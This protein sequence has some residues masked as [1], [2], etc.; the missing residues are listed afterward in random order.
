MSYTYYANGQLVELE[1]DEDGFV[2]ALFDHSVS[3]LAA[4]K[5]WVAKTLD[6]MQT[7]PWTE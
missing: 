3:L 5:T 7:K 6:Y 4:E 1:V 2:E